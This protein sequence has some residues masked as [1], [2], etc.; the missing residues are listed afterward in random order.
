MNIRSYAKLEKLIDSDGDIRAHIFCLVM[1]LG[2]C[3]LFNVTI[4]LPFIPNINNYLHKIDTCFILVR[5]C[6][7]RLFFIFRQKLPCCHNN[8]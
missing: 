7:F 4:P 8:F 6:C 2:F 3:G 5:Y 1:K